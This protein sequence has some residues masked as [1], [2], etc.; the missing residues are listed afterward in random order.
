MAARMLS[1][2]GRGVVGS[3]G[4]WWASSGCGVRRK[5]QA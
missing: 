5:M 2:L 1:V 4:A 3:M